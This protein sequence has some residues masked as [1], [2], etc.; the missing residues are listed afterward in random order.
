MNFLKIEN[1]IKIV[2]LLIVSSLLM[3]CGFKPVLAKNSSGSRVEF[4][5]SVIQVTGK[6][7]ERNQ[8]LI[9]KLFD[10]QR[11][12]T[13]YSIK[14]NYNY[15]PNSLGVMKDGQ[16]T[17]Y[18]LNANMDYILIDNE[19]GKEL[20]SG[21][22]N[23]SGSYDSSNSDFANFVAERTISDQL[24]TEMIRELKIRLS[25]VMNNLNTNNENSN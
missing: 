19:D 23:L 3:S 6:E 12:F 15:S 5:I 4:D 21:S 10:S 2:V 8:K 20:S 1:K 22:I 11:T 7:P 25:F 14:I 16:I 9:E 24:L 18:R 13:K 17:R